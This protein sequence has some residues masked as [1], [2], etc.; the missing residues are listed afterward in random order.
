MKKYEKP[1]AEMINLQID[2]EIATDISGPSMN[3]ELV[4]RPEEP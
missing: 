4:I 3:G 2:E 1:V